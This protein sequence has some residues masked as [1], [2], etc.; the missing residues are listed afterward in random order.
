MTD[1]IG[2]P[3]DEDFLIRY[4]FGGSD[5]VFGGGGYDRLIFDLAVSAFGPNG[6]MID[7]NRIGAY[8]R[9]AF[10]EN[11]IDRRLT[12]TYSDIDEVIIKPDGQSILLRNLPAAQ[13]LIDGGGDAVFIYSRYWVSSD[14]IEGNWLTL[15]DD[16]TVSVDMSG[17]DNQIIGLTNFTTADVTTGTGDDRIM[18]GAGDDRL[19]GYFGDDVVEGGAGNDRLQGGDYGFSDDVM[20]YDWNELRIDTGIDTVSYAHAA[21]GVTVDLRV[22]ATMTY[23]SSDSGSW[24]MTGGHQDTGGAGIDQLSG[25]ENILGSAHNDRL[26]GDDGVNSLWG[27][28]GDDVIDGGAGDDSLD[29]GAGIDTLDYS[30]ASA[31]VTASLAGRI[32]TGGAGS[33]IVQGFENIRGSAF[34]DVLTGNSLANILSGMDGDDQMRGLGGDDQY[35]VDSVSDGV[36]EAAGGGYDTIFSTISYTLPDH[37]EALMLAWRANVDAYGNDLDNVLAGNSGDNRLVGRGGEDV[38]IGGA[39]D[40]IYHVNSK[41]DQVVE[42]A[43]GGTDL[44]ISSTSLK[45][46]ALPEVENVRLVGSK[47]LSLTGNALDN[48]LRGNA[49]DNIIRGR[50]GNDIL[51][52]GAGRDRFMFDTRLGPD[53]VDRITDFVVGEDHVQLARTVFGGAKGALP[54]DAFVIGGAAVDAGDR[55]VYDSI[56][57]GLFFDAD[58][59]GGGAAVQFAVLT[60][61]LALSA[62]DV[63]IV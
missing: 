54:S 27:G 36:I 5:S 30:H 48:G 11:G 47:G 14:G 17:G 61:G 38:M 26:N 20:V 32:A 42:N 16:V 29:G 28:D 53:N 6:V 41:G 1:Y 40:D 18:G 19:N 55:I 44:I 9:R 59:S 51:T 62:A 58:G 37:V 52:G 46:T 57:G 60:P 8:V 24:L 39:G 43:G 34:N 13:T 23:N 56:T 21:D 10:A 12:I 45:L 49:G 7:G 31:A 33:D 25:F 22:K 3:S 4:R 63:M 35:W 15:D 50:D 2:G